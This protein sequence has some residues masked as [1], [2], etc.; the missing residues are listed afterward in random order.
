M[1][2]IENNQKFIEKHWILTTCRYKYKSI[3]TFC[4]GNHNIFYLRDNIMQDRRMLYVN[5]INFIEIKIDKTCIFLWI[6][7]H[8]C[9]LPQPLKTRMKFRLRVYLQHIIAEFHTWGLIPRRTSLICAPI[10]E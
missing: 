6:V 10:V 9:V 1:N 4:D 2:I 8:W 7:F 3:K 5:S